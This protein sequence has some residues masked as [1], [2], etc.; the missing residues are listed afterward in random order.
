METNN[1]ILTAADAATLVST[2]LDFVKD[3]IAFIL[4]LIAFA[5]GYA[6]FRRHANKATKGKL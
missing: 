3:N 2:M 5:I 6:L 4:P 1:Q